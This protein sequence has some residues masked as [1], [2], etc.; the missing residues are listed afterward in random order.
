MKFGM[1]RKAVMHA[2]K[3]RLLLGLALRV[4][5]SAQLVPGAVTR[6]ISTSLEP[7]AGKARGTTWTKAANALDAL[8]RI[9]Q[10]LLV[11]HSPEIYVVPEFMTPEECDEI[12]RVHDARMK[13]H[14]QSG[15]WCFDSGSSNYGPS[16]GETL[17]ALAHAAARR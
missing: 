13:S 14:D 4:A 7:S 2:I 17:A 15:E 9:G 12:A 11:N 6:T 8:R 10:A 1:R 5:A 3:A 16:F